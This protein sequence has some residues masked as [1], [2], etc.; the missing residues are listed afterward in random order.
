MSQDVRYENRYGLSSRGGRGRANY[1]RCEREPFKT[2]TIKNIRYLGGYSTDENYKFKV[3]LDGL[4]VIKYEDKDVEYNLHQ[5]IDEATPYQSGRTYYMTLYHLL[6][7]ITHNSGTFKRESP[8]IVCHRGLLTHI[9]RLPYKT[10]FGQE[11]SDVVIQATQYNDVIYLAHYKYDVSTKEEQ[12]DVYDF[13]GHKFEHFM[14]STADPKEGMN[15]NV[16][17]SCVV[18]SNVGSHSLMYYCEVDGADSRDYDA[19]NP[20]MA[21]FIELKTLKNTINP[22]VLNNIKHRDFW[23][24]CV[25]AGCK[26]L[27]AGYR[28]ND[29][30]VRKLQTID[31]DNLPQPNKKWDAQLMLDTLVETLDWI[32]KEFKELKNNNVHNKMYKIYCKPSIRDPKKPPFKVDYSCEVHHDPEDSDAHLLPNWYTQHTG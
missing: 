20:D 5:S 13:L 12:N 26:K 22:F 6:E 1:G 2:D 11:S 17:H 9:M 7:W 28:D 31:V 30:V 8:N 29:W 10:P 15:L 27:V 4:G 23:A 25:T 24:Q 32:T 18:T 16:T 21:S 19:L 3:G 14:D